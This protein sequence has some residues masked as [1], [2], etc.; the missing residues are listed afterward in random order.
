MG[1][2]GRSGRRHPGRLLWGWA[3]LPALCGPRRSPSWA[4]RQGGPRGSAG[5]PFA[6]GQV[7]Q[8]FRVQTMTAREKGGRAHLGA[9][10]GEGA[11]VGKGRGWSEGASVCQTLG[12]GATRPL[13]A[14]PSRGGPGGAG[15]GS[16]GQVPLPAQGSEWQRERLNGGTGDGIIPAPEAGRAICRS[17]FCLAH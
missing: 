17:L 10:T 6:L 13:L 5:G 2:E 12:E 9:P 15:G 8:G 3:P 14:Q 11:G 1:L 16:E 4:Q 7:A